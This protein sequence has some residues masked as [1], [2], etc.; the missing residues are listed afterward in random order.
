MRAKAAE[1]VEAM[2][3]AYNPWRSP[4]GACQLMRRKPRTVAKA[5]TMLM[6]KVKS[7]GLGPA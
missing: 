7:H 5:T 1:S 6:K 3:A 4:N 2:V